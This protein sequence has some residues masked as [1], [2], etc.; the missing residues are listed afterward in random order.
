MNKKRTTTKPVYLYDAN[1]NF[2]MKF[3]TTSECAEYFGKE[4]DYI[5]HNLKYCKKIRKDDKWFIIKR[6]MVK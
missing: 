6:E 3:E 1:M 5:N 2:I 4:T